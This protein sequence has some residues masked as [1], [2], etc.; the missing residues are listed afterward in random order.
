MSNNNTLRELKIVEEIAG[1]VDGLS[2][3]AF[4]STMTIV[5]ENYCNRHGYDP[6]DEADNL[7]YMTR[8]AI[9]LLGEM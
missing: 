9:E 8:L 1:M 7:A 3:A 2:Y 5:L 6:V 4:L